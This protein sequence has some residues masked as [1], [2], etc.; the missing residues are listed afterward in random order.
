[1]NSTLN[2]MQA[3]MAKR[4]KG[5]TRWQVALGLPPS[6]FWASWSAGRSERHAVHWLM[7]R[8][9]RRWLA[10]HS[11]SRKRASRKGLRVG[12]IMGRAESLATLPSGPDEGSSTFLCDRP[13][14][15]IDSV[16]PCVRM[17]GQELMQ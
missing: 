7:V 9:C 13:E 10:K 17:V 2:K 15:P 4:D 12:G 5:N 11:G 3:D 16:K 8:F 14:V 1:M 6:L